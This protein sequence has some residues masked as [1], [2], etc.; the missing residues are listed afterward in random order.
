M[1]TEIKQ[2]NRKKKP[3]NNFTLTIGPAPPSLPFIP[4]SPFGPSGPGGPCMK[5]YT[6]NATLHQKNIKSITKLRSI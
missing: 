4:W 1:I 6:C 3:G 5:Y 2:T